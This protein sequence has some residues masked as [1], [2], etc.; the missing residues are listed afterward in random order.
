M[1]SNTDLR[2]IS[3][4]SVGRNE[5]T[6]SF[7]SVS[8]PLSARFALVLALELAALSPPPDPPR[9]LLAAPGATPFAY[10]HPMLARAPTSTKQPFPSRS[11]ARVRRLARSRR[12]RATS[13]RAQSRRARSVESMRRVRARERR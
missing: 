11:I 9:A 7:V 4:I 10:G 1:C 8:S 3:L 13:A 5:F 2:R 6:N 12:H